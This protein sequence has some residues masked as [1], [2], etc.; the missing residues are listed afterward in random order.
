[1]A[2][3]GATRRDP[4]G[5][6]V[7]VVPGSQPLSQGFQEMHQRRRFLDPVA[8]IA[9][10]QGVAQVGVTEMCAAAHM[11][12]A[13]FYRLFGGREAMLTYAFGEAF[14]RILGPVHLAAGEQGRWLER[15]DA[16]LDALFEAIIEEPLLAELCLVHCAEAPKASAGSDL[17][18]AVEVVARIL[19]GG[20]EEQPGEVDCGGTSAM[21]AEWL[22]RGILALATLRIRQ[23]TVAELPMQKR[24]LLLLAADQMLG[25]GST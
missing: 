13:S 24:E 1:M 15:V 11:G 8:A 5:A 10:R 6:P 12:R 25:K 2:R 16:A 14:E 20:R 22:A 21:A 4:H 23:G 18:A 9:H 7:R 17:E 3:P 19:A